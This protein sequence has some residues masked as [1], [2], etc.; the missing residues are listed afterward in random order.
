MPWTQ[1]TNIY[2]HKNNFIAKRLLHGEKKKKKKH[3]VA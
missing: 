2:I 1:N 3:E